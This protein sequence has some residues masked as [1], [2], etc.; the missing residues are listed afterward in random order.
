MKL[1]FKEDSMRTEKCELFWENMGAESGIL[2]LVFE[3]D[4]LT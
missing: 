2:F 4:M 1:K 3:S